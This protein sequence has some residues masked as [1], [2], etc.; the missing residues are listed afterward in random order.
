MF[1]NSSEIYGKSK[2][3]EPSPIKIRENC[4]YYSAKIFL[5]IFPNAV[6]EPILVGQVWFSS[7]IVCTIRNI[8]IHLQD[9]PNSAFCSHCDLIRNFDKKIMALSQNPEKIKSWTPKILNDSKSRK[10]QNLANVFCERSLSGSCDIGHLKNIN[11]TFQELS[12]ISHQS[13]KLKFRKLVQIVGKNIS[14][15]AY[16][17]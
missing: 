10:T 15:F 13:Q 8:L 9:S 3:N 2:T 12:Q 11:V 1:V 4:F 5:S 14:Q 16:I 17:K 7:Y 6:L